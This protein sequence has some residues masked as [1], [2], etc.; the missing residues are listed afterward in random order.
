MPAYNILLQEAV[1]LMM[2]ETHDMRVLHIPGD[3]NQIADALSR[4]DFA[5]AIHL[6]PE[7]AD[8]IYRF[9]PYR[10]IQKGP[11]YFLQPPLDLLGAAQK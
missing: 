9:S 3:E 7:L 5:R 1:D 8:R 2:M 11:L 6:R 4:G 10:R